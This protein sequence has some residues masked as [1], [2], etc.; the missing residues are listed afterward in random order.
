[1]WRGRAEKIVRTAPCRNAGCFLDFDEFS[2]NYHRGILCLS[3]RR[4]IMGDIFVE[5]EHDN[6]GHDKRVVCETEY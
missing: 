6:I 2:V 4:F 5:V 1:M 3:T